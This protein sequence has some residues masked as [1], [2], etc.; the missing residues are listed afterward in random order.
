MSPQLVPAPGRGVGER[1]P[2]E[3]LALVGIGEGEQLLDRE[4]LR[5]GSGQVV[6]SLDLRLAPLS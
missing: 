4:R 1:Q 3:P 6:P 5:V 2:L